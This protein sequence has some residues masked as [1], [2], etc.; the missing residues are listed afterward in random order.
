MCVLSLVENVC[1][2]HGGKCVFCAWWK[3]CIWRKMCF[4]LVEKVMCVVENV[5]VWCFV[6]DVGFVLV[7]T[8]DSTAVCFSVPLTA[9]TDVEALFTP[10]RA[11]IRWKPPQRLQY[12][13][14]HNNYVPGHCSK[15][16]FYGV[17]W[18]NQNHYCSCWQSF[19][20]LNK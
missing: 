11:Q 12:Q 16:L 6:E 3:I 15:S 7:G 5:F 1:F 10:D 14:D 17:W 19:K 13:G 4:V 20:W 18:R 8:T 2:A 9:P